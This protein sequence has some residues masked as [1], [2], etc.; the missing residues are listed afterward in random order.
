MRRAH[1]LP[2][3]VQQL[4]VSAPRGAGNLAPEKAGAGAALCNPHKALNTRLPPLCRASRPPAPRR[5]CT[6]PPPPQSR[7]CS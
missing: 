7:S 4:E 1:G 3:D 2:A 6:G 5:L